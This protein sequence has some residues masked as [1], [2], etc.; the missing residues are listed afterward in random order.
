M[1]MCVE[2]Y[3]GV[4]GERCRTW[5]ACHRGALFASVTVFAFD[6]L[7]DSMSKSWQRHE[8][9]NFWTKVFGDIKAPGIGNAVFVAWC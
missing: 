8:R 5:S 4:H 2:N 6:F 7:R 1:S 3:P 9:V